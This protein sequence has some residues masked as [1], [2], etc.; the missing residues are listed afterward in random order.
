VHRYSWWCTVV[1]VRLAERWFRL[2]HMPVAAPVGE[3][4][5]KKRRKKRKKKR[6]EKMKE[7]IENNKLS[8]F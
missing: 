2:A 4:K 3:E 6:S 5:N 1:H 7:K 8:I